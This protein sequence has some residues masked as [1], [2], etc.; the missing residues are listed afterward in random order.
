MIHRRLFTLIAAVVCSLFICSSRAQDPQTG[1]LNPHS[2][3]RPNFIFIL[4]DD[5]RYDAMSCVQKEQGAAARFPWFQTPNM[6]RLAREGVRFR[7]AFVTSSLC[8][9]SRASFLS[10]QY[11][12]VNGVV[13]NHTPFP[14]N[15]VVSSALLKQ[16][17]Y[18]TAY[19]GKWHHGNQKERPGFDHI[20]SFIGQGRYIDCPVNING[21]ITPTHGWVDDITTDYVISF[22]KEHKNEPLDIVVGFK[23]PHDPRQPPE[24]AATRFAGNTP[25][26]VPNLHTVPPFKQELAALNHVSGEAKP[27]L[28]NRT[29]NEHLLDYFRCISAADDCLGRILDALDQLKLADNTIVI[30]TSDNGYYLGEHTLGDKRSAYEESM[31]IPLLL[32]YPRLATAKGKTTDAMVLNIDLAPTLLDFAGVPIPPTMQGKS[33]RPLLES[34]TTDAAWRPVFFYEYFYEKNYATP[35]ITAI[36][37]GDSKLVKYPGHEDWTE[38]F[39]LKSD[40]YEIHNLAND[41]NRQSKRSDMESELRS[42]KEVVHYRVP[43]NADKPNATNP[44]HF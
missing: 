32:R 29:R 39:D 1:D 21:T 23:S 4:T 11:N 31:R 24:R 25:R 38:M 22:L 28:R 42:Q 33:W 15:N 36:R 41:P 14:L 17:G 30:Y 16:A 9:P 26:D 40:H 12:H 37:S 6:D 27:N 34:K 43:A 3:Q 7:N 35:T 13:N 2:K 5:Q 20:Y 8:S 10:G 19:F 18:T 44:G